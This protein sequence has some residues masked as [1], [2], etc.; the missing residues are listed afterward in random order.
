[1]SDNS[2]PSDGVVRAYPTAMFAALASFGLVCVSLG[3]LFPSIDER[4]ILTTPEVFSGLAGIRD[5]L[6][7]TASY[8]VWANPRGVDHV[9]FPPSPETQEELDDLQRRGIRLARRA[10]PSNVT[11]A[12]NPS[13]L[14]RL[15]ALSWCSTGERIPNT[16]PANRAP[17]CRCIADAYLALV[18]EGN[19]GNT[20]YTAGYMLTGG[21]N[22][23]VLTGGVNTTAVVNGT[24]KTVLVNATNTTVWVNW[25][26]TTIWTP[27]VV[28]V[29]VDVRERISAR[30]Y[31]CWDQRQVRRSSVCGE[32]CKTHIVGIALFANIVLFLVCLAFLFFTRV[33][34][35]YYL[36]KGIIVL[37]GVALC[38]PYVVRYPE[39]N[40]LNVAG[41]AIAVFYL[42]VSLHAE[43]DPLQGL[44][45]PGSLNQLFLCLLQGLPLILSAHTIQLGLAG[46][47][48]DIWAILSF[49][50]C[51]GL[52]GALLQASPPLILPC[53][54]L[55]ASPPFDTAVCGPA[56][57]PPLFVFVYGFLS[58]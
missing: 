27:T 54:V 34:W 53:V 2:S 38:I 56:G 20:M 7:G 32:V 12:D 3:C 50:V 42:T 24:S 9:Q 48:R 55:R 8:A 31:R 26:N 45:K 1:M 58:I 46:Y 22:M 30:V 39:A 11:R 5:I 19:T 52:L 16:L 4:L 28:S 37:V 40:T 36:L 51:G 57:K 29:P 41:V 47:G 10:G 13:L 18:N 33:A 6:N 15:M 43:L 17:G 25:T 49:G 21:V 44:A 14:H 23:T 35:N